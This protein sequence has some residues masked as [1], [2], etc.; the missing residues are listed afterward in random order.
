M[1]GGFA[2]GVSLVRAQWEAQGRET[3]GTSNTTNYDG[4]LLHL[5]RQVM[6]TIRFA[7]AM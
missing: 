4:T 5:P 6:Q 7:K 3:T 2:T 1:A